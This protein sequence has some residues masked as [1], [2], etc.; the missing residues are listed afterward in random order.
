[1]VDDLPAQYREAILLT[2]YQG[3]TQIAAAATTGLSV[4]GMKARVQRA[5]RQL[6]RSLTDCCAVELD[7]R[8]AVISTHPQG[9]GR[10]G[11]GPN[12]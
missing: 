11:C 8:G 7:R 2:E 6:K 4:S 9:A 10:S 5:R 12:R 3:A 1:M